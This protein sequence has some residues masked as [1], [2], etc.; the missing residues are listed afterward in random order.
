MQISRI[1]RESKFFLCKSIFNAVNYHYKQ[2]LLELGQHQES[3]TR[4]VNNH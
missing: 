2:R 1:L 4:K 3:H